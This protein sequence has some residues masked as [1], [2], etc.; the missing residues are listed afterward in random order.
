MAL[1]SLDLFDPGAGGGFDAFSDLEERLRRANFEDF[2]QPLSETTLNLPGD[3]D[4][5]FDPFASPEAAE[6]GGEMAGQA[7]VAEWR[8]AMEEAERA[9]N[10]ALLAEL[11]RELRIPD[12][13]RFDETA[14]T[15]TP[16]T[17]TP[18]GP[19]VPGPGP[20][21]GDLPP[22]GGTLGTSPD[23]D[24]FE[25]AIRRLSEFLNAPVFSES[26]EARRRALRFDQ[27]E[28]RRQAARQQVVERLAAQGHGRSSGTVE[29]ALQQ[30]DQAFD[31]LRDR[32]E[33]ELLQETLGRTEQRRMSGLTTLLQ[34]PEL[35]RQA[36]LLNLARGGQALDVRRLDEILK[37][38]REKIAAGQATSSQAI[39]AQ[40]QS[41]LLS[42]LGLLLGFLL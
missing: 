27:L 20:T 37:L 41:D 5:V 3:A 32:G 2:L 1:A 13:L 10:A 21:H 16:S 29:M 26:D 33:A 25:S 14:P 24:E 28:R 17:G 39:A 11:E 15:P 7:H 31:A 9:R 38:E 23:L 6:V 35:R 42:G 19:V 18:G 36:A 8:A 30:V 12:G 40:Q 4:R 34:I 22:P